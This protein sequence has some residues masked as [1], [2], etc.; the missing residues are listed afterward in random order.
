MPL[1]EAAAAAL[2]QQHAVQGTLLCFRQIYE[3]HLLTSLSCT[4]QHGEVTLQ[5]WSCS[6]LRMLLFTGLSLYHSQYQG[7]QRSPEPLPPSLVDMSCHR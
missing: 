5:C 3:G 6:L 7:E 4:P 1:P 2:A